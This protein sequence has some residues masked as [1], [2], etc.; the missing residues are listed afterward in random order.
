MSEDG[1]PGSISDVDFKALKLRAGSWLQLQSISGKP[2]RFDVEFAGVIREKCIFLAIE[3]N[4]AK[5]VN[6]K[7]G[8]Q[9]LAMGFNG[10]SDFSFSSEILEIQTI[11]FVHIYLAYPKS[12][13]AIL[14][15]DSKRLKTSLPSSVRLKDSGNA[16]PTEIKDISIDGA[17][18]ESASPL[19]E[20]GSQ[21]EISIP[22]NVEQ[23]QVVLKIFALIR[24]H[25][26]PNSS[27]IFI[28]GVEFVDISKE[29]KPILYF[30]LF[31]LS[32]QES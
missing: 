15:R 22:T 6:L 25:G 17:L 9:Y 8:D 4:A 28:S 5:H 3:E 19:G 26:K 13:K 29:D 1:T 30:L 12:I 11:P 16:I 23:K 24:H 21:I 31:K 14:V 10:T 2:Q 18:I 7:V 20:V 27:E 32:E